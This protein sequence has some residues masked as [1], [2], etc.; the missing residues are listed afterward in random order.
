MDIDIN[1]MADY[2]KFHSMRNP[3]RMFIIFLAV[4]VLILLM[5]KLFF[6]DI[7]VIRGRSM[8]PSLGEGTPVLVNKAAYG[9]TEPF[10]G[11]Y[12]WRWS[13]PE[14]GDVVVFRSPLD[15][16]ITVKRC[17]AV[18]GDSLGVSGGRLTVNGLELPLKFYQGNLLEN[19][20]SVPPGQCLVVGDNYTVSSDSRTFGFLPLENIT[21][22]VCFAPARPANL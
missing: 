4:N 3:T 2:N 6:L 20:T 8:E 15:G 7:I 21:G 5:T 17:L 11:G 14:R 16:S 22:R 19:Y 10:S 1:T 13:V 12:L 18:G 9:M